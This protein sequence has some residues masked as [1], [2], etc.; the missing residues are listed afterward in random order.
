[1]EAE[2]RTS[3]EVTSEDEY[4]DTSCDEESD[5][6]TPETMITESEDDHELWSLY[7]MTC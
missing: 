6:E 7:A 1:M 3:V 4:T 5:I 2:D